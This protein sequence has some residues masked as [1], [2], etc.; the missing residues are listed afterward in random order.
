MEFICV[1]RQ[2]HFYFNLVLTLRSFKNIAYNTF[3][4]E[5]FSVCKCAAKQGC[6]V[7]FSDVLY[8]LYIASSMFAFGQHHRLIQEFNFDDGGS[9]ATCFAINLH[10][11]GAICDD[12]CPPTLANA[13]AMHACLQ[14]WQLVGGEADHLNQTII[15]GWF[16]LTKRIV[17]RMCS[18]AI[19]NYKSFQK[20]QCEMQKK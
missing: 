12:A 13:G 16:R 19:T 14:H 8:L 17:P 5:I 3:I 11:N 1:T 9:N 4:I 20:R 7:F 10:W 6:N 15:D 18:A 2:S